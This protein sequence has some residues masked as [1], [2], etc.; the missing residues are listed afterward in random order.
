MDCN[1]KP[2]KLLDCAL[3]GVCVVIKLNTEDIYFSM[4]TCNMI[5]AFAVCL[6]TLFVLRF[7]GLVNPVGSYR[8]RSVYLQ[9][10]RGCRILRT[11]TH[12]SGSG[13]LKIPKAESA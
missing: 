12:K 4:K 9:G 6:L 2:T 10:S 1:L 13:L 7:Y 8:A 5:G 11:G 3:T